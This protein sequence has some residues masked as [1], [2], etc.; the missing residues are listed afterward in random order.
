LDYTSDFTTVYVPAEHKQNTGNI[1]LTKTY[2]RMF[3]TNLQDHT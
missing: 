1:F 2:K 3:S